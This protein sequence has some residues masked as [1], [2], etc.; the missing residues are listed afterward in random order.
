MQDQQIK[1]RKSRSLSRLAAVAIALTFASC[2]GGSGGSGAIASGSGSILVKDA[3]VASLLSFKAT[4]D[5]LRLVDLNGI[6]TANLL[7]Q[8]VPVE[9]LGLQKAGSWLSSAAF[10]LGTYASARI[11]FDPASIAARAKD[12]TVVPV[13]VTTPTMDLPFA[14]QLVIASTADYNRVLIDLDLLESLEGNLAGMTFTPA[15]DTDTSDGST[16]QA[17]DEIRGVVQSFSELDGEI[18]INAFVDSDLTVPLGM[19]TVDVPGGASLIREDG[20]VFAT[21]AN[22]YVALQAGATLIEVHGDLAAEGAVTATKIEIEDQNSGAN[23][24]LLVKVEGVVA[25]TAVGSF[26]ILVVEVEKGASIANP[27]LM[28]MGNPNAITVSH[29]AMTRFFR[30][31][32]TAAASTDIVVGQKVKVY[33]SDFIGSP[34]PAYRVRVHNAPASD[35]T[36]VDVT[37]LP[38]SIIVHIDGD[39]PLVTS[40]MVAT[41]TTNVTVDLSGSQVSLKT[42][43][44]PGILAAD[45][46]VGMEVK[47]EGDLAALT[48]TSTQ[49]KVRP[50]RLRGNVSAIAPP[51]AFTATLDDLKDPFG[52]NVDGIGPYSIVIDP[53]A[54]FKKDAATPAEF[55]ALFNGLG[56]GESLAIRIKGVGTATPNEIIAHVI[57]VEVE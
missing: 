52:N 24:A 1:C 6:A 44:A 18:V 5:E 36:I 23:V 20:L 31:D 38:G 51:L 56:A 19:V 45:L 28:G 25:S 30:E 41:N 32:G 9:F 34:F 37:G 7:S 53:S 35:A 14:P 43:D 54:E 42:H 22:F 2:S 15:G 27:V 29:D 16:D 57:E 40:G 12:G 8:S 50:G 55:M 49:L 4:V 47:V 33:L 21:P 11:V 3:P 48:I 13:V 39:E 10:P 17:I 26:D 46:Q